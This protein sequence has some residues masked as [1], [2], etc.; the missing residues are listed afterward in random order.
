MAKLEWDQIG[1]RWYE[2][3]ISKGV[4]YKSDGYGVPWNG[5][6]SVDEKSVDS[7]ESVY[8]DGIR[9]NDVVTV[10]D[11]VGVLRAFCYPEEFFHYEG[12]IKD[13]TGFFVYNQAKSRFG[14]SYQTLIGNDIDGLDRAYKIHL[15]Y[16]LTALPADKT[17][18]TL[19]DTI[20]PMEFEWDIS[21]IPEDIDLFRP[22]AHVSISSLDLDPNLLKDIEDII[23]G[24][25]DNDA[26]LPS[27][28][29]LATFIRKWERLIITDI[30]DGLWTAESP[31]DGVIEMINETTFQITSDTAIYL[32]AD[33]YEISSSEK[34]EEDIW[35]P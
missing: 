7:N 4:L 27:L 6:I 12:T 20:E 1:E 2:A 13:Q 31:V 34:N 10:G 3:G 28:K 23:Y 25:E 16:N 24:T 5:L 29:G 33:T 22:T 14:L 9:I 19:A 35:Q 8:Y 26:Y 32:N 21:G 11:F 30:G 15:L 18:Q 17:Y